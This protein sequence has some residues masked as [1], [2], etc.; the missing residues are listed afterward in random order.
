MQADR[1][2]AEAAKH[3]GGKN[4]RGRCIHDENEDKSLKSTRQIHRYHW[5]QELHIRNRAFK[6]TCNYLKRFPPGL[7]LEHQ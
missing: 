3:E 5:L 2:L 6:N 1:A 4:I 7:I